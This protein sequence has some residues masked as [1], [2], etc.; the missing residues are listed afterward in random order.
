MRT[1]QMRYFIL[2]NKDVEYASSLPLQIILYFNFW[3]AFVW[4]IGSSFLWPLL[5]NKF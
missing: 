5:V 4:I 1:F 2:T 3:F